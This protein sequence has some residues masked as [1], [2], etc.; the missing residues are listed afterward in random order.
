MSWSRRRVLTG[1]GSLPVLGC[2]GGRAE[3]RPPTTPDSLTVRVPPV[4]HGALSG[5]ARLYVVEDHGVPL[6]A[7]ALAVR[8][9]H[10]RETPASRGLAS[11][12]A[13][14]LLEGLEGGDRRALLDRYGELG[15]TPQAWAEPDQLVLQCTVH[16]DD[17]PDALRL[18]LD[19]LQHPTFADEAFERVRGEQRE[20]LLATRGVPVAV[21]G[22]GLLLGSLGLDP[23]VAALADGTPRS[24]DALQPDDV[25]TW[26]ATHGALSDGAFMLAGDLDE[27]QARSWVDAAMAGRSHSTAPPVTP[28][29]AP[30]PEPAAR[31][32][33][34]VWPGLPQAIVGL[35]GSRAPWGHRDEPAQSLADSMMASIVQF[36]LR[37]RLRTS[38][39][40]LSQRWSTTAGPVRQLSAKID[41]KDVTLTLQRL[42]DYL[43]RLRDEVRPTNEAVD[44]ERRSAMVAMMHGFHGPESAL[45][46]LIRLAATDLP[47]SR[48]RERL[49]QLQ[50]LDAATV[51]AALR[52]LFD[53]DQVRMCVVGDA[54]VI[55]RARAALPAGTRV[56]RTPAQLVDGL[57]P[58]S[59]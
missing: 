47:A 40:V 46:Q 8:A 30:T 6:V 4:H 29:A 50:R 11:L 23:P 37:S 42:Q 7:L 21:A 48:P 38:Y 34:V 27:D 41:P 22:L 5:A 36:E 33:L 49:E 14:L 15:T 53:P 44:R 13:S 56:E 39:G 57:H 51:T 12:C 54:S 25:R 9:G 59:T 32:V 1:L 18:M 31:L 2:A 26:W 17:A 20:S 28:L 45:R 3:H 10:R 58:P 55:D 24:L 16:R 19:T 35:G 52:T 43:Q